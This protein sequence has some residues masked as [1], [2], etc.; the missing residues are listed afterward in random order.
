MRREF[1]TWIFACVL[2]AC[3][4]GT[5]RGQSSAELA[6]PAAQLAA[7]DNSPGDN[8]RADANAADAATHNTSTTAAAVP[9]DTHAQ[10]DAQPPRSEAERIARLERA[11]EGNEQ[12]LRALQA[13]LNNPHGEY[14][15]AEAA[16]RE[17]DAQRADQQHKVEE[18]EKSDSPEDLARLKGNL[19]SL[20]KKW[21]LAKERFELAISE[22][23]SSQ[24]NSVTLERKLKS[25]REVLANLRGEPQGA[26]TE[27]VAPAPAAPAEKMSVKSPAEATAP[28]ISANPL[29]PAVPPT[30]PPS[31]NPSQPNAASAD[32]VR[33]PRLAIAPAVSKRLAA[34]LDAARSAAQKSSDAA[35]GAESQAQAIQGRVGIL[36]Q[37]IDQQRALLE[38]ARKKVDNADQTLKNLN[39]DLFRKLM[40]GEDITPLKAQIRE[41]TQRMLDNRENARQIAKH[42][43]ELQSIRSLLQAKELAATSEAATL[44]QAAELAQSQVAS[45][46]NPFSLRNLLKWLL[47]HGPRI[48]VILIAL[49]G[50]LWLARV[51]ETR[52]VS[53]IARR[54]R[55]GS[56]EERENRAKT[57]LGV[58]NNVANLLI[59]GGGV[60]MLLAEIGISVMPLLGG[61]AVLGLAVAFGAQSLIKDYFTGFMVLF[62]QQYLINDVIKIGDTAGQVERITLRMTVLRDMEGRV[63]FIPHGQI[64]TVTNLTHGWSRA[65]FEVGVAYKERVDL[66]IDVLKKLADELRQED[67][68]RF[69]IMND[70]VMLGVDSLANSAVIIKFY[71]QTRP[72]QQWVV[73]REMLRR[74][75]NEF[76]RLGI[77]IP[78][79]HVTVYQGIPRGAEGD[80]GDQGEHGDRWGKRDVA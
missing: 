15:Q 65:V 46:E 38:T 19:A 6:P 27:P 7:A 24:E 54:G 2:L 17:L 60:V 13:S 68:Y 21:S 40:E 3:S 10:P 49:S 32:A 5:A 8:A 47:D 36:Q 23:K 62:E 67:A 80:D 75:K 74:I 37:D 39:E 79:P 66:V 63:H 34:E 31:S 29:A 59:I 78:F 16:F 30:A 55:R 58:F 72:L 26:P 9:A 56:R 73:K 71:I 42:L 64:A 20:E 51:V 45:L 28:T 33:L 77:E 12:R 57:L 14:A 52:L 61:A 43:D 44:R 41:T 22:R 53:L 70:P 25:M 11:I 1:P 35:T 18:A 50:L 76:D 69:L 4:H 48:V